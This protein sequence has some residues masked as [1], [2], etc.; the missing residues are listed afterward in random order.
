MQLIGSKSDNNANM[1][2]DLY[3]YR[4]DFY[5]YES[6]EDLI[7]YGCGPNGVMTRAVDLGEALEPGQNVEIWVE[8][9]VTPRYLIHKGVSNRTFIP[10]YLG[11]PRPPPIRIRLSKPLLPGQRLSLRYRWKP[12]YTYPL[13]IGSKNKGYYSGFAVCEK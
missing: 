1:E 8:S 6:Y 10:R 13:P 5:D 3:S 4:D 7:S 2:D 12:V 9:K 11:Q